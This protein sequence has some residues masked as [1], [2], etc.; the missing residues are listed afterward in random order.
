[1]A[2]VFARTPVPLQ[3][4]AR[5][6]L[7]RADETSIGQA[8]WAEITAVIGNND[9]DALIKPRRDSFRQG[10]QQPSKLGDNPAIEHK[11]SVQTPPFVQSPAYRL[12]RKSTWKYP[13][14]HCGYFR[15]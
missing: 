12:T 13:K 10:A 15:V 6:R 3:H 1:M 7:I 8:D 5:K 11:N 4:P 9:G 2:V 14:A